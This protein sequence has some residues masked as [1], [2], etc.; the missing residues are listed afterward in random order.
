MSEQ[1]TIQSTSTPQ[2]RSSLANDLRNLGLT[3]GMTVLVHSSMSTLGWVCGGPV[4]VIQALQDVLTP[5]GTLIMPAHSANVSDPAEWGN[6]PVPESWWE[7]IREE[8]PAFDPQLTPAFFMGKIVDTFLTFPNVKRSYHPVSSFVAWGKHQDKIT[9][10]HSLGNSLGEDSPLARIYDL[11]GHVLLLGIGYDNNTSMHLGEYRAGNMPV[12]TKSSPVFEKG[13]KVWK[14]FSD[15]QF[16]EE[17]FPAIGEAFE[18]ES[19]V[20]IGKI[21]DAEAR[22][23]SQPAI[24]D[25]TTS[26]LQK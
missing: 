15:I 7:T 24:V 20:N 6:P 2:T 9:D 19:H 4:A 13:K 3:K 10:S 23:M 1:D 18:K 21:G 11:N 26:Y 8:M 14:T 17:R 5:S 22:L 12:I 25:Y 16:D